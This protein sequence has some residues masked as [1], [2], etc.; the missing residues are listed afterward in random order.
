MPIH[1]HIPNSETPKFERPLHFMRAICETMQ[2]PE[3]GLPTRSCN[4]LKIKDH[5][6][7]HYYQET[8]T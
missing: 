1:N 8:D 7:L 2:S 6:N 3:P 5:E 4:Q